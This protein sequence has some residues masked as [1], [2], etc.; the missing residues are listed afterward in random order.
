MTASPATVRMI[1]ELDQ[2]AGTTRRLLA[3][4]PGE[5]LDWT[6]HER[7]FSLRRLAGHTAQIPGLLAAMLAEPSFDFARRTPSDEVASVDELLATFD[8]SVAAA[9]QQLERWS[10]DD[11]AATWTVLSDGKPLMTLP[12]GAAVRSML[13][14]HLYHHRGQL[15]VYLRMLDVPLPSIYGPTADENPFA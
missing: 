6:P 3:A 11:L 9:R 12:R 4:V 15:T 2:E 14:N 5:H 10:A 7:S 13:F 1:A 8:A